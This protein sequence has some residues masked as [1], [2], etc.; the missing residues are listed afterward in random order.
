V[1]SNSTS[2]NF[3]FQ[4]FIVFIN[5]KATAF[6]EFNYELQGI[7]PLLRK[8]IFVKRIWMRP[9]RAIKSLPEGEWRPYRGGH[10]AETVHCMNR[11]KK[12]FRLIVVRR[13]Y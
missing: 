9:V 2:V 6:Y 11:T 1:V 5:K 7:F 10:I 3:S 8:M 13:P 12:A 4:W